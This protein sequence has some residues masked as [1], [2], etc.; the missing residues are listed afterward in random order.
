MM[1]APEW[2]PRREPSC[3]WNSLGDD[4][5]IVHPG[6][7]TVTAINQTGLEIW[8]LCD[9][10]TPVGHIVQ[11]IQARYEADPR[12]I[13]ETV[14]E[15]L[16]SIV[17]QALV[18][19]ATGA[20]TVTGSSSTSFAGLL[21][22]AMVETIPLTAQILVTERCDQAC[23]HCY[24]PALRSREELSLTEIDD[25]LGQLRQA[26]TLFVIVSGGEPTVRPDFLEIL[27]LVRQH[28]LALRLYTNGRN[29]DPT[30]ARA[31]A[32]FSPASVDISLYGSTAATHELVSRTPG[33]FARTVQAIG[34]LAGLGI[35]VTVK[36]PITRF[37][38][39]DH[40]ATRALVAALG[41]EM[42]GTSAYLFAPRRDP[43]ALPELAAS[44]AAIA[45]LLAQDA[46]T[47]C[48][49][50]PRPGAGLCGAGNSYVHIGSD[51]GVFPCPLFPDAVGNIREQAF[52]EIWRKAPFLESL[53]S[54]SFQDL[55]ACRRCASASACG[56]CTAAAYSTTGTLTA[57]DAAS[58]RIARLRTNQGARCN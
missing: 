55:P 14:Q 43:A 7:G 37:N 4:A 10:Q 47:G 39:D 56:R 50:E 12:L 44:D 24:L 9:G 25:L 2:T 36:M 15:F 54:L 26:G 18:A 41:A 23:V 53:R 42:A 20:A 58:C 19:G 57:A 5:V 49:G 33:S 29:I 8:E 52:L 17:A 40:A 34:E 21:R 11:A 1:F 45:P 35:R 22:R 38:V 13:E 6:R 48:E 3:A 16:G 32:G 30:L 27:A 28:H 31:I 51:G 46:A